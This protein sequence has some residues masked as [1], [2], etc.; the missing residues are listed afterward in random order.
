VGVTADAFYEA[1]ITHGN[2]LRVVLAVALGLVG[3]RN[4]ESSPKS[5]ISDR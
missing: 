5:A 3:V 4:D 2:F 1:T